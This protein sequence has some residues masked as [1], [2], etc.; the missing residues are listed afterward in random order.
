MLVVGQLRERERARNGDLGRRLVV[1]TQE[2]GRSSSMP[3]RSGD[4]TIHKRNFGCTAPRLTALADLVLIDAASELAKWLKY[5]S[6]PISP[7]VMM[8]TPAAS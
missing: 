5:D 2:A 4:R 7:S 6:R 1:I 8:S 3:V